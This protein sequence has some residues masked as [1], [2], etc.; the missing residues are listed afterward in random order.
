[1]N[2]LHRSAMGRQRGAALVVAMLVFA[3]CTALIVA[4]KGDFTRLYQRSANIFQCTAKCR[5][6]FQHIVLA[7]HHENHVIGIIRDQRIPISLRNGAPS[8]FHNFSIARH[9]ISPLV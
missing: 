2:C 4:M 6:T 9:G 7:R 8:A 1:M 5:L 3:M